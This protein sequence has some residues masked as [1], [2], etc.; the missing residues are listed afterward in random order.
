M[1]PENIHLR[2]GCNTQDWWQIPELPRTSSAWCIQQAAVGWQNP[3]LQSEQGEQ[4]WQI[5][6]AAKPQK[7]M[8]EHLLILQWEEKIH[9]N[10]RWVEINQDWKTSSFLWNLFDKANLTYTAYK[11]KY[12]LSLQP[13]FSCNYYLWSLTAFLKK[14]N[15]S[16]PTHYQFSKFQNQSDR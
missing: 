13:F 14:K 7:S 16:S 12:Q 9:V 6:G 4:L 8:D 2:G 11:S 3:E 5:P 15:P 10:W 1:A